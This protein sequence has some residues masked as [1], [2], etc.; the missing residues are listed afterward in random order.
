MPRHLFSFPHLLSSCRSPILTILLVLHVLPP[1]VFI[2]TPTISLIP[3]GRKMMVAIYQILKS[4]RTSLQ[5]SS[6]K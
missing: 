6:F 2:K 1:V 5:A 4:Q 3:L